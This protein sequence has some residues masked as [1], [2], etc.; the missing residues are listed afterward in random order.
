[1]SPLL[2]ASSPNA[3]QPSLEQSPLSVHRDTE[4]EWQLQCAVVQQQLS[5]E[6]KRYAQEVD[7]CAEALSML[8]ASTS[9]S[10]ELPTV[11]AYCVSALE[12]LDATLEEF[13][14]VA[15]DSAMPPCFPIFTRLVESL[16]MHTQHFV[17]ID[18]LKQANHL[19]G[20]LASF[21]V[22]EG[23]SKAY[24]VMAA[25]SKDLRRPI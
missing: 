10:V 22:L 13:Y 11:L 14:T 25:Y 20:P 5:Q 12:W 19:H 16:R 24:I 4:R 7:K 21:G 1:M 8:E 6:R 2:A 18:E 17:E 15:N 9:S 3:P 23:P